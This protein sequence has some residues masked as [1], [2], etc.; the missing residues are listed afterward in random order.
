MYT[1]VRPEIA[2]ERITCDVILQNT[3]TLELFMT[4]EGLLS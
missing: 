4:P 1:A 2:A 3:S